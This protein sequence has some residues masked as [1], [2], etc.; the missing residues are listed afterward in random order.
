MGGSDGDGG[1]GGRRRRR[2][3]AAAA[4]GGGDDEQVAR[5]RESRRALVFS[6]ARPRLDA[7]FLL[8]FCTIFAMIKLHRVCGERA[9]FRNANERVSDVRNDDANEPQLISIFDEHSHNHFSRWRSHF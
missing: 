5:S 2:A 1:S 9:A 8:A 3:A 6:L 4:A 7:S